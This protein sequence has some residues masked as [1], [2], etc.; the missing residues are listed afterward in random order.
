MQTGEN[1]V[2][3]SDCPAP[4]PDAV[5]VDDAA[6]THAAIVLILWISIT[7][8]GHNVGLPEAHDMAGVDDQQLCPVHS[9]DGGQHAVAARLTRHD[10]AIAMRESRSPQASRLRDERRR[11]LRG[12]CRRR[13]ARMR[14]S[15]TADAQRRDA[16]PF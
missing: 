13:P 8:G 6:E 15:S 3:T 11:S 16:R 5:C 14:R 4:R 10:V 2:L 12:C 7:F 1:T 9:H